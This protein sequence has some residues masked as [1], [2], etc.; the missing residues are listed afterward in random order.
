MMGITNVLAQP[1]KRAESD[2]VNDYESDGGKPA[3]SVENNITE[4]MTEWV[5]IPLQFYF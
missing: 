3:V 1:G 5:M 2:L 4:R